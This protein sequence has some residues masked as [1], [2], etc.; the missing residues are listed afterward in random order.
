MA[1]PQT[2]DNQPSFEQALEQVRRII[3]SIEQGHVS[4]EESI[5]QYAQGM[6]LIQR[7]RQLLERA[8]SRI[9]QLSID[10]AGQIKSVGEFPEAPSED[11]P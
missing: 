1:K 10:E 5:D 2:Q 11:R 6:E 9:K 8:E 4:L 3:E 7:C